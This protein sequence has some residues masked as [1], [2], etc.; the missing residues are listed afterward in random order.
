MT[1]AEILAVIA[2]VRTSAQN[3][4]NLPWEYIRALFASITSIRAMKKTPVPDHN[5]DRLQY[6]CVAVNKI[7]GNKVNPK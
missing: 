2:S 5:D 6:E 7:V 1:F 4:R 3:R